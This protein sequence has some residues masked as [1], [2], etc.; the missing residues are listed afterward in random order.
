M[1]SLPQLAPPEIIE[2]LFATISYRLEP[3]GRGTRFPIVM[4][5]LFAGRLDSEDAGAALT[6]LGHIEAGLREL[7]PDR[8]VWSLTDLRR[9]DDSTLPVSH[10]AA[11]VYEYFVAEDG[12]PLLAHVREGVERSLGAGGSMTFQSEERRVSVRSATALIVIGVIWA[13]VGRVFFPHYI[14]AHRG[15]AGGPL[16]WPFGLLMLGGGLVLLLMAL[17]PRF[18]QWMR[19][20]GAF[21]T[22]A[23]VLVVAAFVYLSLETPRP[24][25]PDPSRCGVLPDKGPVLPFCADVIPECRCDAGGRCEWAWVCVR[26]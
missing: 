18:D 11:N 16:I 2:A 15:V 14:L 10:S 5:S 7:P 8:V 19:H 21:V 9:F 1:K 4:N 22:V 20:H 25:R 23:S 24:D 3:G 6:E 17:R 13:A 26:K 12:R